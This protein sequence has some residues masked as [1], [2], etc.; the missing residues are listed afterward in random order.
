MT[1]VQETDYTWG[2]AQHLARNEVKWKELFVV[3]CPL[4]WDEEEG[5]KKRKVKGVPEFAT[6]FLASP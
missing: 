3:I 5:S 6:V 2:Q 4:I 1:K